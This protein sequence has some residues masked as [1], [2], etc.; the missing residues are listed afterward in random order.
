M[1]FGAIFA[2]PVNTRVSGSCRNDDV[3][4]KRSGHWNGL[5]VFDETLDMQLDRLVH[6]PFGFLSR[7]SG[8]NASWQIWRVRGEIVAGIL[9]DDEE[10]MH[11]YPLSPA[12]FRMLL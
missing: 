12:C 3:F 5:L 1:G 2:S 8:R 6:S 7:R 4:G 11:F 9:D 10:S